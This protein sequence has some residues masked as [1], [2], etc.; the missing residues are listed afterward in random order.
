MLHKGISHEVALPLLM[1][2]LGHN[3]LSETG[4]Y[5]KLTAE[6]FPDLVEQIN[7]IYSNVIPNL[8]VKFEYEDE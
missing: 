5:L 3:S 6:A 7:K 4:K 2:Y 1:T 8:E